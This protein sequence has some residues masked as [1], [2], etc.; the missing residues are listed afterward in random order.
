MTTP[1]NKRTATASI[2][3]FQLPIADLKGLRAMQKSQKDFFKSAFGNWQ[4]A[5]F[6]GR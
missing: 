5:M 6:A 1:L 4:S 3:D 2:F